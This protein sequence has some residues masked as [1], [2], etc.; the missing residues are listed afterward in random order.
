MNPRRSLTAPVEDRVLHLAAE[1]PVP[2]GDA[3]E[4]FCLEERLQEW[5]VPQA[6]VEPRTGGAYELFWAPEDPENDS[7][8]G[9]RITVFQPGEVLGFQ[10][11]SPR[12]F[13]P[14]ANGADPLT[15]VLASFAAQHGG[16]RI[17]LVHTGWRSGP[18][19]EAAAAWQE[20]AWRKALRALAAAVSGSRPPH[21]IGN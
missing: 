16:A 21:H 20:L 2:P 12:Q 10:W 6:R 15:H 17:H 19:W 4:W 7:T 11:R 14:F 8:I 1:L 5:L 9:C 13:K 3:F 18:E